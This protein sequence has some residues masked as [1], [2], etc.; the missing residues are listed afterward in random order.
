MSIDPGLL[1][2]CEI[3][4][5]SLNQILLP[6]KAANDYSN[7]EVQQEK[8]ADHHEGLIE[9]DPK[10][11]RPSLPYIVN[12]GDLSCIVHV[13]LPP[14]ANAHNELRNH[15]QISVIEI[16][17]VTLPVPSCIDAVPLSND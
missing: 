12:L 14:A 8:V 13:N 15:S 9:E 2:I 16:V 6:I 5:A 4:V 1:L 17:V 7:E 11:G 10:G 3:D